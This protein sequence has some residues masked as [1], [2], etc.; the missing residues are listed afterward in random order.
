MEIYINIFRKL[1]NY[2]I[3]KILIF[4]IL[5]N[6]FKERKIRIFVFGLD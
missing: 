3:R 5:I 6:I 2:V 4:F 1:K